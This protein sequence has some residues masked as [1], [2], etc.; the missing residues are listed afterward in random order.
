MPASPI[1]SQWF[2]RNR[3]L[4]QGIAAAGSG[5]GGI[6]ASAATTPMIQNISLAWSL[7]ITGILS[8]V[9]LTLAASLMR[10][11]NKAIKPKFKAFDIALLKKYRIWLLI[12]YT[13]FSI[14]GYIVTIYSLGET[15]TCLTLQLEPF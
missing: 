12:G 2:N 8:F 15:A 4:A 14:L 3:S 5:I 9:M 11:R 13:F 7:R 1:I 10:D 6:I